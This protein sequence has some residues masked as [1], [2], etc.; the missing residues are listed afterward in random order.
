MAEKFGPKPDCSIIGIEPKS[1][2]FGE[3]LSDEVKQSLPSII[4]MVIEEATQYGN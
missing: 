4:K 2:N 3:K 1:I